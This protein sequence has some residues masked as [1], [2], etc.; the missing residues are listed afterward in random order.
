MVKTPELLKITLIVQGKPDNNVRKQNQVAIHAWFLD[1]VRQTSP[2]LAKFL[3]DEQQEK[4]FNITQ[5]KEE[6]EKKATS[7]SSYYFTITALSCPLVAWLQEWLEN[8]PARISLFH[9]QLRI[10]GA[11]ISCQPTSYNHLWQNAANRKDTVKLSFLT[12][13]S[14]KRK[15]HHFPLPVPVNLFHS[16]LRRWNCFSP[17]PFAEEP[18]LQWIDESVIILRHQIASQKVQVAK[19]GS[20]TGFIGAIEL[21]LDKLASKNLEYTQLFY[22]LSDFA[23]YCGTGHKTTFGLGETVSSWL[24]PETIVQQKQDKLL[25]ARIAELK[26]LFISHRQRQGGDRA[27]KMAQKL[28]VILARREKGESLQLIA[29]DLDIPYQTVKTYAKIARRE[30][31]DL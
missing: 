25:E 21:G 16:Y 14:F 5:L 27:Q 30:L 1:Q 26:A 29:S 18:F 13:T 20:V 9:R 28:A 12:P 23:P 7:E 8:P 24:I 10:T 31:R 3:H 17:K 22:T 15:K 4:A 11:K 6:S 2:D 19:A